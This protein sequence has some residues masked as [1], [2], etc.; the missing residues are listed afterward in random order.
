[1]FG[2]FDNCVV[3]LTSDHGDYVG[4][5]GLYQKAAPIYDSGYHIPLM[6]SWTGMSKSN[7]IVPENLITSHINLLPTLLTLCEVNLTLLDGLASSIVDPNGNIILQDYNVVKLSLSVLFGPFLLPSLRNLKLP[8]VNEL[9]KHKT[10]DSNYLTLQAFSV[11]S[12]MEYQQNIYNSG[13]YFSL[14]DVFVDTVRYW[15][16]SIYKYY[17][18]DDRTCKTYKIISFC[19]K[20]YAFVCFCMYVFSNIKHQKLMFYIN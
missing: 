13:Y 6:L 3:C 15:E 16:F 9:I 19:I 10:S 1:M 18:L 2:I 14:L 20:M 7:I 11:S 17:I 5:H 8:E 4:S 12:I